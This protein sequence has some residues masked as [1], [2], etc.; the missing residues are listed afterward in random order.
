MKRSVYWF[1]LREDVYLKCQ[2]AGV[3]IGDSGLRQSL[4]PGSFDKFLAVMEN[5]KQEDHL[6]LQGVTK[7]FLPRI[8]VIWTSPL[9]N[10]NREV[11][12]SNQIVLPVLYYMIWT[13]VWPI[14]DLQQLDI[15]L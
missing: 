7:V 1:M 12:A 8:S 3:K 5:I 2:M 13:Q 4:K 9:S 14:S 10:S 6:V 15:D 11:F